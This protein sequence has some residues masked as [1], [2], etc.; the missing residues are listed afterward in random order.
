MNKNRTS[1]LRKT[2]DAKHK[3]IIKSFKERKKGL[4]QKKKELSNLK[5]QLEKET[6]F[7]EIFI[8]EKEISNIQE[9]IEVVE[10]NNEVDDYF[11]KTSDLLYKYYCPK[12]NLPDNESD[13]S[14]EI[15]SNNIN[16]KTK[17]ISYY[18]NKES[19]E[20]NE[21]KPKKKKKE[22]NK[23]KILDKFLM[24]TEVDHI[25]TTLN[26]QEICESCQTEMEIKKLE[27]IIVCTN[28]G[29]S[30]LHTITSSKPSYKESIPENNYF[31]YK[32]INHFNEWLSQFQAKESTDIPQDVFDLLVNEI[33]KA[34]I[35]NMAKVTPN[36]IREFL[37]KLGLNKYYE[38]TAY[39]LNRL[40]GETPPTM[41]RETEEKLRVMFREIQYPFMKHCPKKRVNFLSYAYVLHKFVELLG[42]DEY[43]KCFPLLK[44]RNKLEEQ[45]KIWLN[46]C[47]EL[48]WEFIPSM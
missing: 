19:D 6:D 18:F 8:L 3:D 47:K 48:K 7:E 40:N 36:K 32:R 2:L 39:I 46:I 43:I 42:L 20:N 17:S 4:P 33:K 45:D 41:T 16:S 28:C 5:K 23:A 25:P 13:E 44:S 29:F 24:I 26:K 15:I 38:H 10:N 31:A 12:E 30:K 34:R 11:L 37:K 14:D 22:V 35:Q 1:D 9:E 21:N 27:G